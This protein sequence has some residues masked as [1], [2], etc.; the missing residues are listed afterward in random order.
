MKKLIERIR[1][2]EKEDKLKDNGKMVHAKPAKPE[3]SFDAPDTPV[4]KPDLFWDDYSDI[5]YC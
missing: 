3:A 5:G 2:K 1:N 4:A